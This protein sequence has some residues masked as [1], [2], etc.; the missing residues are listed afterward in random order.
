MKC[1][2]SIPQTHSGFDNY[3][4]VNSSICILVNESPCEHLL[5]ITECK[6]TL[7]DFVLDRNVTLTK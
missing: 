5:Y 2:S 3:V 6:V 7:H 1:L 4:S